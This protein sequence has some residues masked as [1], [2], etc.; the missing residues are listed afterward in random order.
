MDVGKL[1]I[2]LTYQDL[3]VVT[4]TAPVTAT[5]TVSTLGWQDPISGL[6]AKAKEV[7]SSL[8]V[9]GTAS[10]NGLLLNASNQLSVSIEN[11]VLLLGDQIDKKIAQLSNELRPIV[12]R[13]EQVLDAI[14][15]LAD[16]AFELEAITSLDIEQALGVIPFTRQR[17]VLKSIRGVTQIRQD[18]DYELRIIATNVGTGESDAR[19]STELLLAGASVVVQRQ[20]IDQ[21]KVSLKIPAAQLNALFA[22]DA[23]RLVEAT[24]RVRYEYKKG[25][26]WKKFEHAYPFFLTLMPI[27][28]GSATLSCKFP[29]KGWRFA[30]REVKRLPTGDHHQEGHDVKWY[31]YVTDIVVSNDHRLV[32]AQMNGIS[33]PLPWSQKEAPVYTNPSPIDPSSYTRVEC[34]VWVWSGPMVF[35]LSAESQVYDVVSEGSASFPFTFKYGDVFSID[36]PKDATA[37]LVEGTLK[38]KRPIKFLLTESDSTRTLSIQRIEDLPT[39]KRVW[40]RANRPTMG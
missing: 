33:G 40:I 14:Q 18:E 30:G 4:T 3:G 8:L 36:L 9:D 2:M 15:R 1:V 10:A 38:T 37:G 22:D 27:V 17:F 29:Q 12:Q 28:A 13:F 24:L 23:I 31:R 11:L 25:F 19:C 35:E 39:A 34:G 16:Q 32:G 20:A 21:H 6:I 5:K 26:G 7:A